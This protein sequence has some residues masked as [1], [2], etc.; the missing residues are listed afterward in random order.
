MKMMKKIHNKFYNKLIRFR[1]ET[2]QHCELRR[3]AYRWLWSHGYRSIASYINIEPYGL[4][5]VIGIKKGKICI[6]DCIESFSEVEEKSK[7]IDSLQKT[8]EEILLKI[9]E[10]AQNIIE[11]N[12]ENLFGD[13]YLRKLIIELKEI[14]KS[15]DESALYWRM[16]KTLS[17]AHL[18]YAFYEE[19]CSPISFADDW[20][21]IQA[22]KDR[23]YQYKKANLIIPQYIITD[24]QNK[25][26]ISLTN[27]IRAI[28]NL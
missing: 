27:E 10:K 23:L 11:N 25:M 19:S 4:I 22:T 16:T 17:I 15:I 12:I 3:K 1:S 2:E 7:D 24:I 8:K 18:H 6:I 5:D 14:N 26:L 21:Y 13:E 28:I 20:G 9:R